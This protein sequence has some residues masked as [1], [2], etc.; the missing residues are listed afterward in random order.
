MKYYNSELPKYFIGILC[1]FNDLNEKGQ[2]HQ[3]NTKYNGSDC[4][5]KAKSTLFKHITK[6]IN[7]RKINFVIG[8][9]NDGKINGYDLGKEDYDI[10]FDKKNYQRVDLVTCIKQ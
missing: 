9:I 10:K 3:L 5:D 4:E 7:L 2:F 8:V 1:S 6:I